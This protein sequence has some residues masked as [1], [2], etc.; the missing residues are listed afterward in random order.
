MVDMEEDV[1]FQRISINQGHGRMMGDEQGAEDEDDMDMDVRPRHATAC[2][3]WDRGSREAA[4]VA[5]VATTTATRTNHPHASTPRGRVGRRRQ[6][7]AD[8]IHPLM[9]HNICMHV[10]VQQGEVRL[11]TALDQSWTSVFTE[12]KKR[13]HQRSLN[14]LSYTYRKIKYMTSFNLQNRSF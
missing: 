6:H 10:Q 8:Q 9:T 2:R 1:P 5:H 11:F 3:G 13:V 4:S 7:K 14:L 12:K